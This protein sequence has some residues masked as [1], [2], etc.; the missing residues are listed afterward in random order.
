MDTFLFI[1]SKLVWL[2]VK[3]ESWIVLALVLCILLA[4]LGRAAAARVCVWLTLLM[5][6]VLGMFPFGDL[7]LAR[8]ESESPDTPKL[9][10]IDGIIVLGGSEQGM[11]NGLPNL[12]GANERL[13]EGVV[14]AR[15][16]PDVQLMSTGGSG[17]L[18]DAMR[19]DAPES[20]VALAFFLRH[21]IARER[22]VIELN[23]RNTAE[24]ARNSYQL[25]QPEPGNTWVIVT[26]AS[27]MPRAVR[28]FER[29]G[30]PDLVAWPVDFRARRFAEGIGWGLVGK[31]GRLETALKEYVGRAYYDLR[32][33]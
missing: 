25:V 8:M 19:T 15:A 32:G 18:R 22:I 2:L 14:L 30:W 1:I 7:L 26:S 16:H 3:P 5:V 13:T 33:I 24:N 20:T 10:D 12:N 4:H 11:R 21:G 9:V 28:S 29:A 31:L 6:V 17:R 27:H 23:S